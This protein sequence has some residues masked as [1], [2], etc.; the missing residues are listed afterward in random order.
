MFSLFG[1]NTKKKTIKL[2]L[3]TFHGLNNLL[4]YNDHNKSING[5]VDS[6]ND[7]AFAEK[8]IR[9]IIQNYKKTDIANEDL[10][11]VKKIN[12]LIRVHYETTTIS[13]LKSFEDETTPLLGWDEKIENFLNEMEW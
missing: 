1:G 13:S 7:I 9:E 4:A 12:A 11:Y 5:S 10:E 8:E 2:L 3:E 6:Y